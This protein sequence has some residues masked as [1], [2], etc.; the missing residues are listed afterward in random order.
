MLGLND[1]SIKLSYRTELMAEADI[2]A[3]QEIIRPGTRRH[4]LR[5]FDQRG[6]GNRQNEINEDSITIFTPGK[7]SSFEENVFMEIIKSHMAC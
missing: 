4:G 1:E 3:A 7:R 2:D 5:V 6:S